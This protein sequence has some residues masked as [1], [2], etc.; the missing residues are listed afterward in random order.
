[1]V[2]M[3]LKSPAWAKHPHPPPPQEQRPN[4]VAAPSI[5]S[6]SSGHSSSRYRVD[7]LGSGTSSKSCFSIFNNSSHHRK[8]K[9]SSHGDNNNGSSSIHSGISQ[10]PLTDPKAED[11]DFDSIRDEPWFQ[12]L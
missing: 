6:N 8:M 9:A 2:E 10:Q 7:S 12:Q 4:Y 5:P 11:P 3:C 1:M